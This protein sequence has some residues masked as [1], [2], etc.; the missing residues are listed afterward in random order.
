MTVNDWVHILA[1]LFI[2]ASLALGHWVS[3]YW[4]L[5]TAFVGANLLQYGI[6]KFCPMASILKKLGVP[7]SRGGR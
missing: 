1:G 7:E 2:L 4:L 3:P 6:S 5:F